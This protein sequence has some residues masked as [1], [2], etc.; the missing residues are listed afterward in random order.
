VEFITTRNDLSL[1]EKYAS[2][3]HEQGFVV[4]FGSEHNSPAMEPIELLA[5]NRTPLT[6][7]LKQ[8]NY[9]GACVIAAHQHLVA[10]ELEGY[11]NVK[12]HADRSKREEFVQL[13]AQLIAHHSS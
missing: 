5:R 10:Q 2:Y 12:G 11:V 4:T 13:G 1:L 9:E 6:D 7:R 8:I 3:L